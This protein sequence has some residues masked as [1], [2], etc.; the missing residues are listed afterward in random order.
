MKESVISR[1]LLRFS[2]IGGV[3]AGLLVISF[4]A[5][6]ASNKLLFLPEIYSGGSFTI[7]EKEFMAS[8]GDFIFLP[9]SI[10][11]QFKIPSSSF[12]CICSIFPA[13]LED[14]FEPLS[15]PH[16]SDDIPPLNTTPPFVRSYGNDANVE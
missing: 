14:Y 6:A 16:L 11:H 7:G 5:I 8:A 10:R 4:A 12:H 15:I 9:R 2:G 3:L 13:G 1:S